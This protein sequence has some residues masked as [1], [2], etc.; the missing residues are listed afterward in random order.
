MGVHVSS[1]RGELV[2]KQTL[3]SVVECGGVRGMGW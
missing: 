2:E 3:M 1:R